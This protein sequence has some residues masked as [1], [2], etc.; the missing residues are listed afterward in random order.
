MWFKLRNWVRDRFVIWGCLNLSN[1]KRKKNWSEYIRI[2]Y[3]DGIRGKPSIPRQNRNAIIKGFFFRI[4]G[5][6]EILEKYGRRQSIILSNFSL[7]LDLQ[8]AKEAPKTGIYSSINRVEL[9]VKYM[10][11]SHNIVFKVHVFMN[12]IFMKFHE[13]SLSSSS[14]MKIHEIS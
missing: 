6:T 10:T 11:F 13:N 4:P 5:P 12:F 14:Y 2:W 1:G 8:F 7:F 3:H 9:N